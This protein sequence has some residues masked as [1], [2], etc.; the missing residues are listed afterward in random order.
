MKNKIFLW[1]LIGVCFC[2]LIFVGCKKDDV[3]APPI[4]IPKTP[5]VEC[6]YNDKFWQV[7]T[8]TSIITGGN[9]IDDQGL[10]ITARGVCWSP[11]KNPTINDNATTDSVGLGIFKQYRKFTT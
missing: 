4:E 7:V 10:P 1:I 11:F 8:S 3:K 6:I 5:I 2:T 9:V